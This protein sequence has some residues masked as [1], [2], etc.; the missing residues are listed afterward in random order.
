MAKYRVSMDIGGTFTDVIAFNEETGAYSAGKASTTPDDL[1]RGVFAGL[2]QVVDSPEDISFIVH[3][4]TQGLNAF[5][6]RRGEKVLLL[7]TEGAGDIYQIARGHRTRLY[8]VRYRKPEPL[9]SRADTVEIGGRLG[10]DGSV[11]TPLDVEQIRA[12][13]RRFSA[14]G[15]GAIAVGLLFSYVN[16]D[17]ELDVERILRDELGPD[18][19]ITLSHQV[20][21]EWREYERT[22]SAVIDAYTAPIVR[23]YLTN[24]QAEMLNRGLSVTLHVM[25]SSGGIINANSAREMTL[26]TLFSGPVGGAVGGVAL[27]ERLRKPNLIGVDMGGTS[28]DI[29]LVV[30]GKPDVSNETELEGFPLLM[31]V[32]NIHTI[33]AGGGSI[34]YAESGGLRVGPESAGANPGPASYMRGGTKPTVTDAN[35]VLGRVDPTWFAG[36]TM[37]L[38]STAAETAVG[39]LA[40]TLGLDLVRMAEGICDVAN[41]KMAQAI[42]NITVERGIEPRDFSLVAFGGAG[43]MHAV[44]LARELEIGEVI[45]PPFPGAFSAWGM[46]ETEV[47]R[48][49]S[50][51][52]YGALA[53]ADPG[54]LDALLTRMASDGVAALESDGLDAEAIRLEYSLDMRYMGQEYTLTI[55]IGEDVAPTQPDFVAAASERFDTAHAGRFGHSNPGAP[56]EVVTLRVAAFGQMERPTPAPTHATT[57]TSY[58]FETRDIVFDKAV[59]PTPVIRRDVLKPGMLVEGPAV[60][61]E[62][63]ATTVLPPHTRLSVD[64]LGS[65][66]IA[67]DKEA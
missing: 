54:E 55:P 37:T 26:Q 43:P 67:V 5:L 46:L 61:V 63:T 34:A 49:F 38:D 41:A 2:A 18:V 29:S 27:S 36:G 22:S 65:L 3:G 9:V 50:Q 35:L 8:D 7:A 24:L 16:P 25:Q 11:R 62:Q 56:V 64:P 20:A 39:T 23:R 57:D 4:T 42:R 52:Y 45:V 6:Q 48:D 66:V 30:D 33:G 21:R 10:P 28:F 12:A 44:F 60:I 40:D 59:Y 51:S 1:T 32:V 19:Q 53:A 13:A 15:F 17:H 31:P 58:P 47:R 14:E